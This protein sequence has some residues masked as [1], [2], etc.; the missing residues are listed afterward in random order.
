[1][2][3]R[4]LVG[5]FKGRELLTP[6]GGETVRP[7]TGLI[8]KSLFD[9]LSSRFEGAVVA[10]LYCA[11]GTLGLEALSRGA[12]QCFFAERDHHVAA[13][14]R[15]NIQALNAGDRCVVWEG[16]LTARLARRL[17]ESAARIDIAFVDPPFPDARRWDWAGVITEIFEP[18][19]RHLADDGVVALRLPSGV[20]APPALGPLVIA[21]EKLYG[22]MVVLLLQRGSQGT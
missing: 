8:R 15:R 1:M 7:M 12:R 19:A 21:R 5:E 2:S 9:I 3:L 16:D 18:L 14:L 10:D 4:I 17:E 6:R 20:Q 11:T 13:L 22:G